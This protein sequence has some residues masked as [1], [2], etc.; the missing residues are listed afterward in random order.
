MR[1]RAIALSARDMRIH[2][3]GGDKPVRSFEDYLDEAARQLNLIPP[4][5]RLVVDNAGE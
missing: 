2:E 5:P 3:N 4:Q 1:G